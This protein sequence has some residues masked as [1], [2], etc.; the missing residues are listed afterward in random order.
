MHVGSCRACAGWSASSG[1]IG[2][3]RG[4]A[5]RT[6][7]RRH[8]PVGPTRGRGR[9]RR[10]GPRRP[11]SSA[12]PRLRRR[13]PLAAEPVPSVARLPYD[14]PL[15]LRPGQ[16]PDRQGGGRGVRLSTRERPQLPPGPYLVA[17]MAGGGRAALGGLE[18][19]C[20]AA[21]LTVW[22]RAQSRQARRDAR[23]LRAG[24]ID[25]VLGDDVEAAFGS[26]PRCLVKS[27]G[28]PVTAPVL[29]PAPER[30]IE[31]VDELELGW[32]LSRSP[33]VGV[34]GT[35]GKTTTAKLLT[36]IL[37]HGG[38]PAT[39]VGNTRFGPPLSAAPTDP[40]HVL[41][42]EV[43]SYQLEGCPAFLPDVAMLTNLTPDHLHRH[44]TMARYAASKRRMFARADATAPAAVLNADD[45]LGRALAAELR[46]RG[47]AVTTF[48][49]DPQADYR[50]RDCSWDLHGS[51]VRLATPDGPLAVE[52]LLPGAHNALNVA[53]AMAAAG[54]LG[55][56]ARGGAEAVVKTAAPPGRFEL[57]AEGDPC[58]VV[59]DYAHTP[60]G[61][62]Q[63]LGTAR[64]VVERRPGARLHTVLGIVGGADAA[65][66]GAAGR[67]AR[68][69]SDR[70]L[71]TATNLRGEPPLLVLQALLRGARGPSSGALKGLLDRG[72]P[73]R[74]AMD[75]AL[76]GDV[77]A[78]LGRGALP[79]QLHDRFGAWEPFDDRDVVREAVAAAGRLDAQG[80][81]GA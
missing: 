15:M 73:I 45:P 18:P 68:R 21:A 80:A 1:P 34:A 67:A 19:R 37:A 3:P 81:L 65:E 17:G 43:S 4:R 24:G 38:M 14:R 70:L 11:T 75:E 25:V 46:A 36:A 20:G 78:V 28:I 9:A 5:S 77:V 22:D 64:R 49:R 23:T 51:L 52:T 41:V 69:L 12:P 74:R 72:A 7:A 35:N 53:A 30:G 56:G 55:V 60:D 2:T 33:V 29:E 66:H 62:E 32:R 76:A 42:C 71:L 63:A 44:G 61:I 54:A 57:V 50:V 26:R 47:A 31:V 10:A 8:R 59:V 58:D 27:P 40:A 48:G 13:P 39:V 6:G 16:L 79:G